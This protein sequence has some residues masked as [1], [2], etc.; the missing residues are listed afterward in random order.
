MSTNATHSWRASGSR[1]RPGKARTTPRTN[2]PVIRPEIIPAISRTAQTDPQ[3]ASASP[4]E[5]D[6][7]AAAPLQPDQLSG[8][9][10][11]ETRH[12]HIRRVPVEVWQR[13]R[14]NA[15]LSGVPFGEFVIGVLATCEPMIPPSFEFD[16]GLT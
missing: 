6:P 10:T 9:P 8:E 3:S 13:A 12:V 2:P 15:L 5:D 4:P 14:R 11:E 16:S 1:P 7:A